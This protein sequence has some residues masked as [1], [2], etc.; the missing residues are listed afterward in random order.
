MK[1]NANE[2]E[3]LVVQTARGDRE[4]LIKLCQTIAKSVLFRV[5]RLLPNYQDAED[6]SQ[7]V[8]IRVCENI[9][10]LKNPASFEAWVNSIILNEARRHMKQ[11]AKTTDVL[12]IE[13]YVF[14]VEEE[15]EDFLPQA[16]SLR[17]EDCRTI[18]EIIDALPD[19]QREVV[20]LYYYRGL[21]T[22]ETAEVMGI[23]RATATQYLKLAREK[24]KEELRRLSEQAGGVRYGT[25]AMLPFGS[26]VTQVFEQE[27][28]RFN[29]Y[30]RKIVR[31]LS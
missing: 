10:T 11:A 6:V 22:V 17:E 28:I 5:R 9:H 20:M 31:T 24:I 13:D 7:D 16:H 4:A 21:K 26:L 3:S 29:G 19:R 2:T 14:E 1:D 8:L 18:I 27:A 23:S 15:D 12:H 30:V 25:Y